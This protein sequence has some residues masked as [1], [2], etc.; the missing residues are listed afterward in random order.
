MIDSSKG[1][2]SEDEAQEESWLQNRRWRIKQMV[3][4][5]EVYNRSLRSDLTGSL[6]HSRLVN[7]MIGKG[8]RFHIE[9]KAQEESRL[10]KKFRGQKFFQLV[11]GLIEVGKRARPYST[12]S[13]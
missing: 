8:N 5:G 1:S 10:G 9:G 6:K 7:G 12:R 13:Y 3:F 4:K 11:E 2:Q